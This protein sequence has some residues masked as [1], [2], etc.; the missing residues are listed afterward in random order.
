MNFVVTVITVRD[1]DKKI[2]SVDVFET[3]ESAKAFVVK[4]A[5]KNCSYRFDFLPVNI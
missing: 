5:D 4:V 2:L 3:E 1:S